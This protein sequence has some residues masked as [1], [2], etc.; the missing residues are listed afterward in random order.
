MMFLL[1]ELLMPNESLSAMDKTI[2][3]VAEI[4]AFAL[5]WNGVDRLL[6]GKPFFNTS[7]ILATCIVVSYAGVKW[8]QIKRKLWGGTLGELPEHRPQI[9]PVD[10]AKAEKSGCGLYI[11]NPGY[12]ALDVE[13]PS[14]PIGQSGFNLV[15][16]ER[17]AQFGERS[18]NA[19]FEAWLESKEQGGRDGCDLHEIMRN[20]NT[21]VVNLFIAYKD[22][23]SRSFRSNCSIERTNR[24]RNGLEVRF[25]SQEMVI[26]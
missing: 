6:D 3:A 9:L 5:G 16:H 12:D 26:E 23:E 14:V 4:I 8:P 11:R 22:T 20:S 21:E 17:L 18:G 24:P 25:I 7:L 13:I 10:Y 19:F 15:F 2:I 1:R